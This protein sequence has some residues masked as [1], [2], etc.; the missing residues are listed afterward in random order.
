MIEYNNNILRGFYYNNNICSRVY[1]NDKLVF[2]EAE[3]FWVRIL[4]ENSDN[5]NIY[6]LVKNDAWSVTPPQRKKLYY[7]LDRVNWTEI[8]LYGYDGYYESI[9]VSPGTRVYFKGD[10][11]AFF[12]QN[13]TGWVSSGIYADKYCEVGGNLM[14]LFDNGTLPDH[15][16]SYFLSEYSDDPMGIMRGS[17]LKSSAEL[18]LPN[19][20]SPYCYQGMFSWCTILN[21]IPALPSLTLSLCC[22]M[23]MFAGCYA[24]KQV[25]LLPAN[26][27]SDYCYY[28][29]FNRCY[30][31]KFSQ[32]QTSG[33]PNAYRINGTSGLYS[34]QD[35]F[36]NTGGTFTG[37]PQINTTY[38]TNATII[39]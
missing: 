10:S 5:C 32:T 36:T 27:L 37:T 20:T 7:S 21:K 38:Y 9:N 13:N 2:P 29:M 23:D 18:I 8:H 35:M 33:Y 15:A 25:P 31:L 6:Y 11:Q 14:S 34:L 28:Y 39:S 19:S 30:S 1:W 12:Y 4:P 16:C 3:P 26:I 24:L 17:T 22:Y